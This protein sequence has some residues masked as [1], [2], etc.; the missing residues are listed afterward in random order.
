VNCTPT[1]VEDNAALQITQNQDHNGTI[2]QPWHNT[3]MHDT[4][5]RLQFIQSIGSPLPRSQFPSAVSNRKAVLKGK[6][7]AN[8]W[9][10]TL[11]LC[12]KCRVLYQVQGSVPSAGFCTKCRVLYQVQC[13]VPS[14]GFCTKCRVLYL[15]Q[16]F[17]PSA[18]FC[19]KCRVL[20]QVQG[21]VPSAGFCT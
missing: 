15:V 11:R 3:V 2:L 5:W 16:G 10:R 17:V 20:C 18:G 7:Q 8:L 19:T 9:K 6:R 12:T 21:F 1:S 13:F 14:A 4:V